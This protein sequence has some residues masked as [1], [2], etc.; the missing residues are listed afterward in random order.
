MKFLCSQTAVLVLVTLSCTVSC[1]SAAITSACMSILRGC[2]AT[3][4]HSHDHHYIMIFSRQEPVQSQ[5]NGPGFVLSVRIHRYI[6]PAHRLGMSIENRC[7][8]S[9]ET[10]DCVDP[11]DNTFFFCLRPYGYPQQADDCPLGNYTVEAF[12]VSSDVEERDCDLLQFSSNN[13][14]FGSAPNPLIFSGE[15]WPVCNKCSIV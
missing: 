15:S 6:N 2:I 8:D 12:C 14:S 9:S 13:D 3:G 10:S 7:C 5:N 11:C 1:G 4:H